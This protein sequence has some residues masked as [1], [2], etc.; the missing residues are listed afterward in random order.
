MSTFAVFGM[1]ADVALAEARKIT[2]TTKPSGKAGC[3]PLELTLAEWNLA[4]EQQAAK[5]MAGEK[6]KQLSQMFDA[7]QYAQQFMEPTRKQC[8]CRDL[9]IRAKCV[10]TD[11]GGRPI[12]NEKTKA[13]KVGWVDYLPE[14]AVQVA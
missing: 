4:V 12:I 10:L 8:K 9:R 11:A 3:P 2:K 14:M 1:T 6:V 7:P 13:P 5:I